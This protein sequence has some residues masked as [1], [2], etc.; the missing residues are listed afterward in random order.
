ML[1]KKEA[2]FSLNNI[3]ACLFDFDGVIVDS[4]ALHAKMKK[5]TLDEMGISYPENIF[6][7]FQ[8]RP[9]IDFF[10]FIA[11]EFSSKIT[12]SAQ[13]LLQIKYRLYRDNLDQL[14]LIEG[15]NEMVDFANKQFSH[16]AIVTSSVAQDVQHII[17][18]HFREG[19][20]DQVVSF[21]DTLLH[22]PYPD[23]Y[24][25]GAALCGVDTHRCLVIEDSP[26][27]IRAAK[28][29]GC[30]AVGITT[31]FSREVLQNVDADLIVGHYEEL[32]NYL[33][34]A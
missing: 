1:A 25:K 9:D 23:P 3:D 5:K 16:T 17:S 15:A 2:L 31:T 19:A 6:I 27:G 26:S 7:D 29:A 21:E 11:Q 18:T 12:L 24:I 20:F 32:R 34:S 33:V 4:E 10:N 14:Q 8:G 13:E 22:K 28:S 30:I